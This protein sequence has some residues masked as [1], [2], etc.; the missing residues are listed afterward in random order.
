MQEKLK[1]KMKIG[2]TTY[3]VGAS[4]RAD[5]KSTAKGKLLRLMEQDLQKDFT[6]KIGHKGK[7]MVNYV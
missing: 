1:R 3:T 4:F 7:D 2:K 6:R 5:G